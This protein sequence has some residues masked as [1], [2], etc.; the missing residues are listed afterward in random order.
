MNIKQRQMITDQIAGF[1]TVAIF[2]ILI[3]WLIAGY[4]YYKLQSEM[5]FDFSQPAIIKYEITHKYNTW[6]EELPT[7]YSTKEKL[8]MIVKVEC[9]KRKLDDYCVEDLMAMAWVES[10]FNDK[11]V[12]DG[13]NSHGLFQISRYY[14]PHIS[15]EQAQNI[16]FAT[17]FT[18]DRLIKKGYPKYRSNSIRL[19]NGSLN[20]PKTLNYL[21]AVNRYI[22]NI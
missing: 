13:G 4:R 8:K 10:R 22:D 17:T 16:K 7:R 19:H 6:T 11:A 20:N 3:S 5:N 18:L 9:E 2:F 12:G 1:I 15:I 21:N 14:H